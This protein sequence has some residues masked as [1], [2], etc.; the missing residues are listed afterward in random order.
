MSENNSLVSIITPSYNQ[1][2]YIAETLD[3]V[4]A[5]NYENI[6]HIVQD[7]ESDDG[8]TDI[9]GE[10]DINWTSESDDGQADAINSAFDS[11]SGEIIGWLNS[12]DVY[13]TTEIVS[14]VVDIFT[15]TN[16]DIIYGDYAVID[17]MSRILTIRCLP[18]FDFGR[19]RRGCFI[20]Q[21]SVFFRKEIILNHKLNPSLEYGMDYEFWL[22]LAADGFEF[23][24]IPRVFSGDRNYT[25]RKIRQDRT[26]MVAE[27]ESIQIQYGRETGLRN[28][29]NRMVDITTSGIPRRLRGGVRG[30]QIARKQPETAFNSE[31][32][33][34]VTT[35]RNAFRPNRKLL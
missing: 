8:T 28:L 12:D 7:G 24:H 18:D 11:A 17:K 16:A 2:E 13:F 30:A 4:A 33:S 22:R 34:P 1:A 6:E 35:F 9:L 29:T 10:R 20:T 26:A 31:F 5:Q 3:S 25:D 32:L 27:S 19:L 23:Q 14:Q 21:P 15:E